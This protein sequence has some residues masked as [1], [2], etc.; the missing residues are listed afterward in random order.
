MHKKPVHRVIRLEDALFELTAALDI[1]G[2]LEGRQVFS[3]TDQTEYK[4]LLNLLRE[5][6]EK[7]VKDLSREQAA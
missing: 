6:R 4:A 5:F 3:T 2:E 7:V 1:L